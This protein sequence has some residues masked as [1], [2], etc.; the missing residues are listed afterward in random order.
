MALSELTIKNIQYHQIN[1]VLLKFDTRLLLN[2]NYYNQVIVC[3]YRKVYLC[4]V[5]G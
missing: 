3:N 5:S 1:V 2:I 4:V